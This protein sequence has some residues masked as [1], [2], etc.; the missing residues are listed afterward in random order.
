[1][2]L[3]TCLLPNADHPTL[4]AAG[5]RKLESIVIEALPFAPLRFKYS[6]IGDRSRI[7]FRFPDG[8]T[9]DTRGDRLKGGRRVSQDLV[10]TR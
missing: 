9:N 6:G 3:A 4:L 1:M 7:A 10:A 8:R 5:G 2:C